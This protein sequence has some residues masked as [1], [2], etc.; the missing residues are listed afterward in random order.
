MMNLLIVDDEPYILDGYLRGIPWHEYGIE[1]AYGADSVSAAREII[2]S[3]EIHI[4]LC[5]IEMPLENGLDFA[6]W[7]METAPG[8]KIIFLTGHP[9]FAY[10]QQAIRLG[11]FDYLLKPV[12]VEV[13]LASVTSAL[14]QLRKE[15]EIHRRYELLEKVRRRW[16]EYRPDFIRRFFLEWMKQGKTQYKVDLERFLHD[17]ELP[18]TAE[19]T[20]TPLLFVTEN[21]DTAPQDKET[22]ILAFSLEE[23]MNDQ[24]EPLHAG[25]SFPYSDG[26]HMV[27]LFPTESDG[28]TDAFSWARSIID[29]C[30]SQVGIT[31]RCLIGEQ[32]PLAELPNVVKKMMEECADNIAPSSDIMQTGQNRE[33]FDT[34]RMAFPYQEWESLTEAGKWQ[35]MEARAA[36]YLDTLKDIPSPGEFLTSYCLNLS[37]LLL[38]HL[39]RTGCKYRDLAD[40]RP[41]LPQ[42]PAFISLSHVQQWTNDM[43]QLL[44]QRASTDAQDESDI[45]KRVK[46]YVSE[47]LQDD[48]TREDLAK[49][50]Y[51][52][53]NYLSRVFRQQTGVTL[54]QYVSNSRMEKAR[55]L[56]LD[57]SLKISAVSETVGIC[58]SGYFTKLFHDTTGLTPQEYRKTYRIIDS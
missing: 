32:V 57:P 3:N 17:C 46:K 10:T 47:H 14:V 37:G 12:S 5:D 13:L 39:H 35:E 53:P 33:P 50:A 42:T 20:I 49:A 24:L 52:H 2:L 4:L 1:H 45:V 27:L 40:D 19:S 7:V 15:S 8:S 26:Q 28:I 6:Q 31:L 41:T 21:M 34:E 58:N 25:C 29:T 48:M 55:R 11:G 36:R 44:A 54:T 30:S 9:D 43:I 23:L 22:A 18:L 38:N 16:D 56:L 51:V